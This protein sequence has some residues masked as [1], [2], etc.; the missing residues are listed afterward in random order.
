MEDENN[1][2][3]NLFH[4]IQIIGLYPDDLLVKLLLDL[5]HLKPCLLVMHKID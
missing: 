2:E 4:I 3:T 5:L 1:D